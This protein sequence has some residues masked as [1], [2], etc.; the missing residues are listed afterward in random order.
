M[1]DLLSLSWDQKPSNGNTMGS[2][3]GK[4]KSPP[5]PPTSKPAHLQMGLSKTGLTPTPANPLPKPSSSFSSSSSSLPKK[6]PDDV[7]GSLMP[8]F[9][10]TSNVTKSL[11]SM[12]LE[13]RRRHDQQ[14]QQ[15]Q[16]LGSLSSS[17]SFSGSSS[18][19]PIPQSSSSFS[20]P[21]RPAFASSPVNGT[22]LYGSPRSTTTPPPQQSN[23][24]PIASPIPKLP[25]P[26]SFQQT[27]QQNFSSN[28][29]RT[30][31]PANGFLVSPGVLGRSISPSM[32]VLQ[33]ERSNNA[34]PLTTA[35]NSS[36]RDPFDTLLGDQISKN[37]ASGSSQKNQSLNSI[38]YN[39]PPI[40]QMDPVHKT[41][42]PW[43]LDFLANT[44]STKSS[45][46][47]S[48]TNSDVFDLGDF[49]KAPPTKPVKPNRQRDSI[50]ALNSFIG[51]QPSPVASPSPRSSPSVS[52]KE[53]S[54][55]SPRSPAGNTNVSL[56]EDGD[57][58]QIVGMGFSVERAKLALAMTEGG[59]DIEAAIDYLVQNDEAETQLPSRRRTPT[60]SDR[61]TS[62]GSR[63][64]FRDDSDSALEDRRRRNQ[65][66]ESST[67]SQLQQH[68][69][70]FIGT[71]S[72]FGMS[73]LSKANEIYKQGRD[74]VQSVM[75]DM[76]V[77]EPK[78]G[79]RRHEWI[80][81]EYKPKGGMYKDS[82]SDDDEVFVGRQEQREQEKRK[83]QQQYQ[84]QSQQKS[85]QDKED[86]QDTYVSSSRRGAHNS[87]PKQQKSLFE[88][89]VPSSRFTSSSNS[90]S[91]TSSS[92][93]SSRPTTHTPSPLPPKPTRPQR[94]LV[95]ASSQ[96][97]AESNN[98]KEKGNEVF[99]LGQFGQAAELYLRASQTLPSS[100]IQLIV[101]QNNRA[102]AL[103]KTGDYRETV[104]ECDRT[105]LMVQGSDGQGHHDV[106]PESV[107]VNLKDHLGKAL[108][109]RATAYENLEKYKEAR[110]DWA[111]LKELEPGHRNA[112]EGHRRCEKALAVMNG[113]GATSVPAVRKT[114]VSSASSNSA[115]R[116]TSSPMQ[117]IFASHQQSN[118]EAKVRADLNKSEGV[119]K[120]RQTA[121]LQ[122]KEED[123]KLRLRDHV[124]QKMVMWK[125][126]KEDNV[127][128]LIAS[129][130][131]VLW[132]G[133]GWK[134]VGMHELVTPSQVKIKYMRAIGKVHPD[135]LSS[136]TTVEQRMMANT[137]FSTLNHAWDAFKAQNNM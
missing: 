48:T 118:N 39:T 125:A 136:T 25:Q 11:N 65:G 66:Q 109:R 90:R 98:F 85:R 4:A 17:P 82:D 96:Q 32:N 108:M 110:N 53:Q 133:A 10:Q 13:E 1:D 88:D 36:S 73:V 58:A 100:H 131:S 50:D 89:D 123:E 52:K 55:R 19:R 21:V 76:S 80:E 124:D 77:D 43:D 61:S 44:T 128:A 130:G 111:K 115:F 127:R 14:Q 93:S 49:E 7:F 5:P 95:Q 56:R 97:L 132:E 31:S 64:P 87:T 57:I 112:A 20:Q 16:S 67:I 107:G 102:A 79:V 126:G 9:G 72:V 81:D 78:S 114:P 84:Q 38:R 41:G 119:S 94:V 122:E 15:Q 40:G 121:A 69:E 27:S 71:A 47:P 103:L 46:P 74:K 99:K 91:N 30:Q 18:A 59:R 113:E 37:G 3:G 134:P 75:E 24:Q 8:S 12:T 116:A 105:I 6:N 104:V 62:S 29:S 26:Q 2:I 83:Q 86:F 42:D 22:S 33:P 35:T 63:R 120:L 28:L 135:K 60:S 117:D 70:K 45:Q 54:T 137:I 23:L 92:A 101:I 51:K 34:S 129:L 106:L 68:K